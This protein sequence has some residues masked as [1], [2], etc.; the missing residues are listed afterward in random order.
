VKYW[1]AEE[2]PV[3]SE[4]DRRRKNS[5]ESSEPAVGRRKRTALDINRKSEA[6]L[7]AEIEGLKT[8]ERRIRELICRA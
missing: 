8:I 3:V 1:A 7:L 5:S 4:D 2:F 6:L